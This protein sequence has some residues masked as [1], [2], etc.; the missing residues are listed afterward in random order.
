MKKL[1]V[2]TI[3]AA[4]CLTATAQSNVCELSGTIPDNSLN[5]QKIYIV[6]CDT[7]EKLDSTIVTD[8]KLSFSTKVKGGATPAALAFNGRKAALFILEPGKVV[9]DDNGIAKGTPLNDRNSAIVA[10]LDSLYGDYRNKVQQLSQSGK[11]MNEILAEAEKHQ[12]VLVS[13][14]RNFLRSEFEANK[15][16]ALSYNVFLQMSNG[17][18]LAEMDNLLAGASDWLKNTNLV[19]TNRKQAERF[20]KTAPGKM[21]TDFSVKMSNG[22]TATLSDYVGKGEYVLLDFFASWC[23]PCMREMPNLK[24]LYNKYN[25]KGLK[26]IGV[27]VWDEPEDTKKCIESEQLPWTIIDNAQN[28]HTDVYGVST[29]IPHIVVFAPDGTIAFRGLT[30]AK[31]VEAVDKVMAK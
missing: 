27:A 15:D 9:L 12:Q 7:D 31:L 14:T 6:N 13:S 23:G 28:V 3:A 17:M 16:N 18:S 22:K 29:G 2:L 10:R 21:F 8:R 1:K 24:S 26:I 30:G 5:G 19:K 20:E 25:G 4:C 11:A